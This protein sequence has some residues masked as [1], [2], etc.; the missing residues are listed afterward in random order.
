MWAPATPAVAAP[1]ARTSRSGGTYDSPTQSTPPAAA[2]TPE[3]SSSAVPADGAGAANGNESAAAPSEAQTATAATANGHAA[4]PPLAEE[5]QREGLLRRIPA[6]LAM[7]GGL[8]IGVVAYVLSSRRP[9]RGEVRGARVKDVGGV[10]GS[11]GKSRA[12]EEGWEH[13]S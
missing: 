5:R 10:R 6:P 4:A 7:A 13:E 12:C 9:D 8:L 11:W 3:P 1:A 2:A